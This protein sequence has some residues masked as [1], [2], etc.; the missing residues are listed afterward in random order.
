[1]DVDVLC[2]D[3]KLC[4]LPVLLTPR[5]D[6]VTESGRFVTKILAVPLVVTLRF[7]IILCDFDTSV[8]NSKGTATFLLLPIGKSSSTF[9]RRV[10]LLNCADLLVVLPA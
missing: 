8:E 6:A 10:T 3:S 5:L 1:M 9:P 7:G 4:P 2:F